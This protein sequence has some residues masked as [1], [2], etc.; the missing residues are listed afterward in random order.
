MRLVLVSL[1]T[2]YADC[3]AMDIPLGLGY[4]SSYLKAHGHYDIQLV[5]FNLETKHDYYDSNAYLAELPLDGDVYG[6]QCYTPQFY[7]LTQVS[8]Y[9]KRLNKNALIVAGGP[10]PSARPQECLTK[11][12]VDK[13]V[14]GEGE[15]VMLDLMDGKDL[16]AITGYPWIKELDLLPFPDRELVDF[17]K[18]KRTIHGE[19]AFH[20]ITSRGCPFHCS[21]CSK[22]CVGDLVRWRSAENFIEEVDY[23]MEKYGV[24]NFV[25]YDDVFPLKKNRAIQIATEL[26]KRG[27]LW[28]CWSR[29]DTLTRELLETFKACGLT[30]ITF[31]IESGDDRILKVLNKGAT[32]QQNEEALMLCTELK[33]PV[34]ASIIYGSPYE[35]K[36]SVD[37]TIELLKRT[38][39]DEWN[40]ATLIP[41]P[42]SDI[43]DHPEKYKIKIHEDPL[44]MNYHR[45]G[46]S[47]MGNIM[48]D[49]STMSPKEYRE[50]REYMLKRLLK[51][52]P[53]RVIQD[54]I[55]HFPQEGD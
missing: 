34:R 43:G 48:V 50:T 2:P 7:W 25:I 53:R 5:D 46:Q 12:K 13:V 35:T 49:I 8:G 23:S 42:G 18:Y 32:A 20:I 31:G 45:L 44:Y 41:I 37:N 33:I 11:A 52:V 17:K 21:F 51:E 30:S 27:A 1:P 22:P 28:R 47:G 29:V 9:I 54:T 3:P 15:K 26:S 24:R 39:P 16:G 10:H 19:R 6:I 55:Q 40:I 36:E 14:V 4:I 38:Q